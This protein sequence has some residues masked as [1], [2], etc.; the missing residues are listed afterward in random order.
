[1]NQSDLGKGFTMR[2]NSLFELIKHYWYL[3]IL[4]IILILVIGM[5]MNQEKPWSKSLAVTESKTSIVE[6]ESD[7][8]ES[9]ESP[10]ITDIENKGNVSRKNSDL[11][12]LSDHHE[13]NEIE[14]EST[15]LAETEEVIESDTAADESSTYLPTYSND[16]YSTPKSSKTPTKNSTPKK[17]QSNTTTP[18][19]PTDAIKESTKPKPAESTSAPVEAPETIDSTKPV[20]PVKPEI[21]VEHPTTPEEPKPEP[22][23]EETPSTESSSM[24]Q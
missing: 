8:V 16:S 18:K 4:V 11:F 17:N 10:K 9:K 21:P 14:E 22:P 23:V 3:G 2:N 1:M 13:K 7:V 20:E 19:Q 15:E 12:F 6:V 24:E 5:G